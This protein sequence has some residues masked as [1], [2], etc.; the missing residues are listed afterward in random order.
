MAAREDAL[1]KMMALSMLS[2]LAWDDPGAMTILLEVNR[3]HSHGTGTMIRAFASLVR[4]RSC[5]SQLEMD[6]WNSRA[7]HLRERMINALHEGGPKMRPIAEALLTCPLLDPMIAA[8]AQA[9]LDSTPKMP[10]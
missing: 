8:E 6:A 4:E 9:V 1:Y 5:G 3:N 10:H 2:K 7:V